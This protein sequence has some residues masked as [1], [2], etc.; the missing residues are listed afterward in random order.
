MAHRTAKTAY[1]QLEKR[2]NRFPQ[3]APPSETL[4]KILSLLFSEREAGL[5]AQ[6]PI[7]PFTARAASRIWKMNLVESKR[8][9]EGLASRAVLLDMEL[10]GEQKYVLPPPMAGF[11][12]FSMMRTRQDLNQHLLGELFYQY[13]N[14]EED[15]IRD[16]FVSSETNL[17][18]TFV[19]ERELTNKNL[20]YILDFEKASHI[21]QTS[22]HIGISM[23]YCRHKM[24]HVGKNCDAPVDICMTFGNT[25]ASLIKHDYARNVEA[26]ECMELLHKAY[27][28]NLLQ[29]GENTQNGVNFICNCCGC[30]CEALLA[31]KRFG[32]LN[33]VETSNYMPRINHETCIGCG[34]CE[35]VC[36]VNAIS[37][38][39]FRDEN[40]N[41][42][43]RCVIDE[44]ICLG[45]G[46]CVRSCHKNS[47]TLERRK[48]KIIT[49][50]NSTYR[51]VLM[52][53]E[54]GK[55][56]DLIFDNQALTSHRAMAAILGVILK[57][58]PIKRAMA[59]KQMKSIY[60][61]KIISWHSKKFK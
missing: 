16:L 34:K 33:P 27:E 54:K 7:K 6:L 3:G 56:Q 1:K 9:L 52:A 39:S 51:V 59:S 21:I 43:K 5:V 4:F 11:F 40:G 25:A 53:I 28:R 31:A 13:L 36:P 18:R 60:L 26:S 2:L 23:C 29:F 8:V 41:L 24:S 57:I 37:E 12:E 61:E 22:P 10:K 55:L 35:E 38:I 47:I 32:M 14:V 46:V 49:P 44:N 19:Q 17:G 48:K 50:V 15:F 30:C 20:G 45:C 58:P 42:Q